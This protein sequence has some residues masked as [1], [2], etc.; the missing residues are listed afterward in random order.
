MEFLI[1]WFVCGVICVVIAGTKG[2]SVAGFFFIGLLL[3]P[4]GVVLSAFFSKNER[5]IEAEKIQGG[6]MKK[7][8]IC[9]ELV[10]MEAVKC[11][12][13]SADVSSVANTGAVAKTVVNQGD[14]SK[15]A[16]ICSCGQNFFYLNHQSGRQMLCPGCR[17]LLDLP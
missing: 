8:P 4:L 3:G 10:R 15:K 2:R 16:A 14:L 17:A 6:E 5:K 1:I 13:C 7:C 12:Y 11:R 9:A